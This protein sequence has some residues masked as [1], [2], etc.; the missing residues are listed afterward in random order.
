M[1]VWAS[2]VKPQARK[3]GTEH[4][5]VGYAQDSERKYINAA[6]L[7]L[8]RTKSRNAGF[9]GGLEYHIASV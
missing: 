5:D 3:R 7:S 1:T 8:A 9:V 2:S 6:L 4:F